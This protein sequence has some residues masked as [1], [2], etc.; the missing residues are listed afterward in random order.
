MILEV[1]E[2]VSENFRRVS[3]TLRRR[4]LGSSFNAGYFYVLQGGRA[5]QNEFCAK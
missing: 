2:E 4:F 5:T 1:F 3:V